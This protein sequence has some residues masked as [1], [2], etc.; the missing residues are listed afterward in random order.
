M[1]WIRQPTWLPPGTCQKRAFFS[2][3]L[4]EFF[5]GF[6]LFA[7]IAEKPL[8]WP[9]FEITSKF[10]VF[11]GLFF[12]F[13]N[14]ITFMIFVEITHLKITHKNNSGWIL[15]EQEYFHN[16][17]R[18][19][20]NLGQKLQNLAQK[21]FQKFFKNSSKILNKFLNKNSPKN[22]RKIPKKY[23]KNT[24]KMPEK[25]SKIKKK[26]KNQRKEK[27]SPKRKIYKKK[28]G[29][30]SGIFCLFF[31]GFFSYFLP[32]FSLFFEGFLRPFL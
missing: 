31:E 1:L 17:G 20:K 7:E 9:F 28:K 15:L 30:F 24:S 25:T 14:Q 21:F 29:F 4:W 5:N 18:F 12:I 6:S 32:I 26:R 10:E 3:F 11:F 23:A 22:A 27:E 8:F 16:F 13:L 2:V 19:Q